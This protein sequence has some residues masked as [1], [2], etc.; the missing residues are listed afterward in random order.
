MAFKREGTIG[1][2]AVLAI[3]AVVGY[4]VQTGSRPSESGGERGSVTKRSKPSLKTTKTSR[5]LNP[6]CDSLE[7][8]LKNFLDVDALPV[9]TRCY[10]DTDPRRSHPPASV[11][12]KTSEVKFIVATLPDPVH[13]HLPVVF[14]QFAVAIQEGAQDEQYDFDGSWLPWDD[15]EKDTPYA[16]F[17]DE[18]DA[19]KEKEFKESQPG[20]ILFRNT[21][22]CAGTD[23]E[24]LKR[25][26]ENWTKGKLSSSYAQGLVV[27]VVGEE[28]THGV[29]EDQFRNALE[30]IRALQPKAKADGKPLAI[31]G[32]TFS[33]SLPSLAQVLSDAGVKVQLNLSVKAPK[34][35]Q[36]GDPPCEVRVPN[37]LAVYSGSVSSKDS[38]QGFQCMVGPEVVFH[39]FL[40]DDDEVLQRFCAYLENEQRHGFDFRRIAMISEDETAYGSLRKEEGEDVD[41]DESQKNEGRK[42]GNGLDPKDCGRKILK[43]YY[44]RDISALRG[45]YQ[46]KS[47]FNTGSSSQSADAQRR[48]LPTDLADP[49]GK[50]HDSIRSYGG[51]QTPLTQEAF[52]MDL[53]AALREFHVRHIFLRS[54]NTLD[55]VFLTNFLRRSYPDGRIVIFGS[56]L[57]FIRE[58]G[59]TGLSGSL[60][61]STYP[62]FPLEH[63][64]TDRRLGG[65]D[66]IFSAD[67]AEG[68]YVAFRLLLN[69]KSLNKG[70]WG[71]SRCHV[72][73][74]GKDD[75]FV[76]PV[77]CPPAAAIPIPD[78]ALPFWMMKP[79]SDST[80]ESGNKKKLDDKKECYPGPATW[81]SV[82]GE[83]RFWPVAAL[84]DTE[85]KD[86]RED[87]QLWAKQGG[88]ESEQSKDKRAS[89]PGGRPEIPL[90]MK[91]FFLI[92]VGFALFHAWCCWS[93]SYTAKPAFRAHFA[94]SGDWRHSALVFAGSVLVAFLAVVAGWGCG[95]F[96]KT[97]NGLHYPAEARYCVLFVCLAALAGILGNCYLTRWLSLDQSRR[98]RSRNGAVDG[99]IMVRRS[100]RKSLRR[101]LLQFERVMTIDFIAWSFLMLVLYLVG[102]GVFYRFVVT[103]AEWALRPENRFLT[104]WRAMHLGS[105]VSP[106]VPIFAILIGLYL[107]FWYMLHGLALFG[108]DK[109]CLPGREQLAL[110]FESKK[111][112]EKQ[113]F[114]RMFS[115]EDAG[116]SIEE[117]A[118]SL[119][120]KVSI[121]C[122]VL[123]A[124]FFCTPWEVAGGV[125]IRSLGSER[126][127]IIFL[128]GL[129][130]C[131][132]VAL[133]EAWR[134]Y[135]T[136]EELRRLLAFID[137]IAL[138]RT[139][140]ALRG[141]SWGSVWKMSGNV[142]EVR[143]K[144]ISRQME[145]MNHTIAS[146]EAQPRLF[147]GGVY[148][149]WQSLLEMRASGMKF[150][151]WYTENYRKTFAGDLASF[152][153][154][155]KRS[156]NA[157]GCL[158]AKVLVPA[159]RK[160]E[161]SLIAAAPHEAN[162][163]TERH[164]PA[165]A[166][167]EHIRNAEEFVCLNYMGFVQNVLGRLRTMAITMVVLFVAAT[168]AVSTYPFDPR[169][170]LSVV[171]IAMFVITGGVIVKVYAEMH[172]NA[173]L[174]HVTNTKPG[175]LGS[176]FW[177]KILGFG[178]APLIGLLA[179]IFPGLTDVV[180][181]WLQP[182]ISSLK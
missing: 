30:W 58:R 77:S 116:K 131:C 29:H 83:N 45:A 82:I 86:K 114:L 13:T 166:E 66:R 2:A 130:I 168:V 171:L 88:Q 119:N 35:P 150:A 157:S 170:A 142:L 63:R 107:T 40:R 67:G 84:T 156:A 81:L 101:S 134:F 182:G 12:D 178:F 179:R 71:E 65:A 127:S 112:K 15:E 109:P 49:A 41:K 118:I 149:A 21:V 128:V 18:K 42:P 22:D 46:T 135:K 10:D 173:T 28:A 89:E 177:F 124:V 53:V 60:T 167:D 90:E 70:E 129:D 9:P 7:E 158:L 115:Q 139:L 87:P 37:R 100:L 144:V 85:N 137:R 44:P 181:S 125:P 165:Q 56:D 136:W 47:L 160:E 175:E 52:L 120:L 68:T 96:Q 154:F 163:E 39:S 43:L 162:D 161:K 104:Y 140:I 147:T 1:A 169:Q 33:G 132:S 27:F 78:Y 69:D 11:G 72:A 102:M 76:P 61:L 20:I 19:N 95:V 108:A 31:L 32:P 36:G 145:C 151:R 117:G 17:Q 79:V 141:F 57:M 155:Q 51:N 103:P 74:E 50:V 48:G 111:G 153:E 121:A 146:L 94:S 133:A 24:V 143:Y 97:A 105:G 99:S 172:R 64:W 159:W 80:K 6:G 93:G 62:L 174:S 164:V 73:R 176:E 38:A 25:C 23:T 5:D 98:R 3:A 26:K 59:A 75:I 16:L 113:Y 106:V 34:A 14:D 138:R 55:Q 148:E 4:S 54:S 180:F 123:V 91:A 8:Q 110:T 152:R 126:Y 122:A 92:L